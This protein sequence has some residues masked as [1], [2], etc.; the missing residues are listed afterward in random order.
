MNCYS[1][2]K[3]NLISFIISI[4]IFIFI[5]IY[6]PQL[7]KVGSNYWYY[8]NQPNLTKEYEE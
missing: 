2:F 8:K 7:Y 6:I 3:I 1:K 5:F 4:F